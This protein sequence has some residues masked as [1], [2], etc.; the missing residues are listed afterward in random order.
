MCLVC[1][2]FVIILDVDISRYF[3]RTFQ[4]QEVEI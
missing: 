1:D 4:L 2:V 3:L